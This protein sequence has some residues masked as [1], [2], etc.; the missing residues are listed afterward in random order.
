MFWIDAGR[1]GLGTFGR[2]RGE[3]KGMGDLQAMVSTFVS[4]FGLPCL[5]RRVMVSVVPV[6]G[7]QVM[8]K[9]VP[10]LTTGVVRKLNGFWAETREVRATRRE[11]VEN[12][13]LTRS[14]AFFLLFSS[15]AMTVLF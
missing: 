13:I 14:G 8:L 12:C 11:S 5:R 3:R 2:R 9:G 6:D 1:E 4:A 15:L 7:D 10:T